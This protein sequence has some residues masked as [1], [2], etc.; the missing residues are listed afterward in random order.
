MQTMPAIAAR[1][2]YASTDIATA[3]QGTAFC[4]SFAA[5]VNASAARSFSRPGLP[6]PLLCA[7]GMRKMNCL[8]I[9]ALCLLV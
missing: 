5:S 9:R 2:L 3:M 8:L 4:A 6:V 7:E 1:M